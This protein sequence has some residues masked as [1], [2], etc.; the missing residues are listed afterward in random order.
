MKTRFIFFVAMVASISF[1]AKAAT[2]GGYGVY[3]S[4][5]TASNCPSYC[6]TSGGGDFQ[7]DSDG[8]ELSTTATSSE[9]SYGS[10]SASAVYTGSSSTYLPILN[11]DTSSGLG[12]SASAT[13]FGVQGYTYNGADTTITLDF[14]LHGSVGDNTSGYAFN[15]LRADVAVIFGSSLEWYPSYATLVYEVAEPTSVMG[16]KSVFISNGLDQ[17]AG[18]SISFDVTDG[19]DFYVVASMG[20][21]AKNGFAD[22][23]NT[24]TMQF[25]NDSGLVAASVSAVPVP[26]AVWLFGSGLIGMVGVARR[27]TNA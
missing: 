23:S 5:V 1:S 7:Y 11:I 26:A 4:T 18:S 8:F 24:F 9:K 19:L 25:D 27:K 13:A 22:A 20:A 3:A 16:N 14:N 10:A 15:Q 17:N 6:T 12:R 2:V 21:I